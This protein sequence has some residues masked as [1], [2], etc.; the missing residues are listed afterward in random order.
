M[1]KKARGDERDQAIISKERGKF[2]L[3]I[4]LFTGIPLVLL[5]WALLTIRLMS[6]RAAG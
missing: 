5:M 2:I 6:D 4:I 1:S 3:R